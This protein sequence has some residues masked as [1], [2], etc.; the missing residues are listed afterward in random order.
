MSARNY[1]VSFEIDVFDQTDPVEACREAWRRLSSP[2]SMLPIGSVR[3][4]VEGVVQ[5]AS[6]EVDLNEIDNAGN[7]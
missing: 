7:E 4:V 1:R 2:D 3:E 5:N 6:V